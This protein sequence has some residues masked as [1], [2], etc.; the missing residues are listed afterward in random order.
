MAD[1][2]DALEQLIRTRRTGDPA[3]SYVARLTAKGRAKI[4]Q[5]VGEEAVEAA[6]AAVQD[7]APGL[8]GEAADLVFHLLVLLADMGL[9]LDDIRAELTRREGVSGLDEKAARPA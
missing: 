8:V 6:I 2:L 3:S 1:S 7:D 5:K 9:S 4:A